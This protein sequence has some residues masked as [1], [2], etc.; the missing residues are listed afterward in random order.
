[1]ETNTLLDVDAVAQRL[2][3]K[4]STVRSYH[5]RG[6]MPRADRYFGRSPVWNVETIE[7]WVKSRPQRSAS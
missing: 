1:M 5:K 7:T 4:P 3:V 6:Q 2:Q